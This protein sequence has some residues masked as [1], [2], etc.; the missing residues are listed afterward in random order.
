MARPYQD[1]YYAKRLSMGIQEYVPA[2]EDTIETIK[3]YIPP[4][5]EAIETVF[6]DKDNHDLL[7]IPREI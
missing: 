7:S 3:T 2:P 4:P 5:E 1:E 6:F